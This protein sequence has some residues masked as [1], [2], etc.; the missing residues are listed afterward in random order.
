LTMEVRVRCLGGKKFEMSARHH[1]I[2]SDQPLENDGTDSAMTPPEVFL[3][4]IGACAAYYAEEYLRAR[5][6]P[7]DGLE[8]RISASKGDRPVR[9]TTMRLEVVARGL[10]QRHRDGILRAVDACLLKN[11]L[12]K[13]PEI[14][15][16]VVSG[17]TVAEP[18][19]VGV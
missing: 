10:T 7:D 12:T 17:L 16:K 6:L 11:T 19:L 2:L 13:P 4:A 8:I 18:E 9:I 3:S 15:V 5:A 14:E 1:Q